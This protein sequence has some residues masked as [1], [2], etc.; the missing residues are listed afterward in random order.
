M[1]SRRWLQLFESFISDIRIISKEEVSQD[2]R[3]SPL[4]LWESQRR[5]IREI[6]NGLDDG[7]HKFICTKSRQLGITTVS[8]AID[9]F[10]VAMHPN[11]IGCIVTDD[12]K[13]RDANRTL[14][15]HY[16]NSFPDNY[17]GEA[18]KIISD[19]RTQLRFSNGARL[20]LLVAGTRDKGISWAQGVGYT[21]I[22]CT[23]VSSY[24]NPEGL[25]SLEEGFSQV[26]P[27]RLLM[28]ESTAAGYNHWRSRYHHALADGVTERG[29]FIGWWA[30]ENNRVDRSDPRW[31][32]FG[33]S[34]PF[35]VERDKIQAVAEQYGWKITQE[36][37]AWIRWKEQDAG[38]EQELLLQ[39]QPWTAEE[40]FVQTGQSFF[41]L[42]MINNHVQALEGSDVVFKGYAYDVDGGFFD[43]RMK[44]L[45]PV[46]DDIGDVELRVWEEPVEGARYVIGMDPAYGRND[47]GDRHVISCWRCFADKMVQV[48]EYATNDVET[49]HASW[50]L[51]HLAA[52][53][54]DCIVNVELSG[55]GQLVMTEF[56]HLRQLLAAEMNAGKVQARE[57]QSAGE[58]VRW[59]LYHRPD[60]MGA[61]YLYNFETSWRTKPPLMY[62]FKGDYVSNAFII[63]SM[64][65]LQEMMNVIHDDGDIGAPESKDEDRKDDRVFAA[66]FAHKAWKDWVRGDMLAEGLTYDVVMA[67]TQKPETRMQKVIDGIVYGF[68]K[69]QEEKFEEAKL[70]GPALA[71][72][73][74]SNGL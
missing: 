41:P 63:R 53:Y 36:Q 9:L 37:L 21:L 55:P 29:F 57:W 56:D 5:Y 61:G 12:E 60:S 59:Y 6:G 26:S 38:A 4:R 20:D 2:E 27:A 24:G 34:P 8:L 47:H 25:R 13:K 7:C 69:T 28:M 72:W 1:K 31:K 3:G 54:K 40:S 35:G 66:A 16:V 30:A 71:P 19:N 10:W 62:G 23:E 58:Q 64:P 73:R 52:A 32:Q 74:D 42:R 11:I 39:N 18:F 49:K 14:L 15:R 67:Y 43:F 45:N 50:V 22:H 17:F 48:A 33:T 68:L 44:P 46:T 51:F 70:D 65:L